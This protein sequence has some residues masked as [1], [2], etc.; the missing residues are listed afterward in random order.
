MGIPTA[1]S[2]VIQMLVALG[3]VNQ[4]NRTLL[5]FSDLESEFAFGEV[6]VVTVANSATNFAVNLATLFPAFSAVGLIFVREVSEPG[7]VVSVSSNATG[8]RHALAAGGFLIERTNGIAAPTL[9]FDNA[10]GST[11]YLEI[12]VLGN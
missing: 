10:S 12:G 9:Y 4:A 3:Q 2:V 1:Q 5:D 6:S 8:T 7:V 11:A